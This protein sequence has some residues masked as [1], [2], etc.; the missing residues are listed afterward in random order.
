MHVC[1]YIYIYIYK[2]IYIYILYIYIYIYLYIYIYDKGSGVV[3]WD[4]E[5]YIAEAEKQFSDKNVCRDVN[6]KSKTLQDLAETSND[7]FKI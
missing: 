6:S 2:H 7:I 3:V 4:R 5:D 1:I